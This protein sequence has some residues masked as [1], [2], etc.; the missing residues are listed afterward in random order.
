MRLFTQ[1]HSLIRYLLTHR[2]ANPA[3]ILIATLIP[4]AVELG[5]SLVFPS[6]EQEL[7][8]NLAEEI[9]TEIM[10][11]RGFKH[12]GRRYI[13]VDDSPIKT[14]YGRGLGNLSL[15]LLDVTD[16]AQL[17]IFAYVIAEQFAYRWHSLLERWD[18]CADNAI[19]GPYHATQE[20]RDYIFDTAGA[21][22]DGWQ[23]QQNRTGFETTTTGP[24]LD[25]G[26]Y[27]AQVGVTLR[28]DGDSPVPGVVIK[29]LAFGAG[30]TWQNASDPITLNPHEDTDIVVSAWMSVFTGLG[31]QFYIEGYAASALATIHVV[32]A[33]WMV[34]GASPLP[35]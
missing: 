16:R 24:V 5:I 34:Y 11:R 9:G 23:V 12:T 29:I 8:F 15:W 19:P 4:A 1:Q 30:T 20:N 21:D 3:P 7:T 18:Y 14:K 35:W 22:F 2:C 27:I 28:H 10:G 25:I 26:K 32:K 31:S 17:W 6:V 33:D 13:E